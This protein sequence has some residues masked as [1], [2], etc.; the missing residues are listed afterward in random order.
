MMIVRRYRIRECAR[1]KMFGYDCHSGGRQ[2]RC[3]ISIRV[4]SSYKAESTNALLAAC[5]SWRGG[6]SCGHYGHR[7]CSRGALPPFELAFNRA[8][9]RCGPHAFAISG[10]SPRSKQF[11]CASIQFLAR[12]FVVTAPPSIE[13]RHRTLM[14]CNGRARCET[15]NHWLF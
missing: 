13:K 1:H 2:P 6:R 5:C 7:R 15:N 8:I 9:R 4:R 3:C 12:A 14:H 10:M 11:C